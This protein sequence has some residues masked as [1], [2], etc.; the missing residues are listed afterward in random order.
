MKSN[1]TINN[2]AINSKEDSAI[3]NK[4]INIKKS[5]KIDL[6]GATSITSK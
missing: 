1:I 2:F 4:A 6:A 5:N 3:N